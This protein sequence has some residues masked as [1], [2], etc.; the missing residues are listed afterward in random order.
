MS[1]DIYETIHG[2]RANPKLFEMAKA[3]RRDINPKTRV[4]GENLYE[5]KLHRLSNNRTKFWRE[6]NLLSGSKGRHN[7]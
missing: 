6:L 3:C 4:A 2:G 1:R 5:N 7:I